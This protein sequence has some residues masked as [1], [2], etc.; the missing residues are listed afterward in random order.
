MFTGIV[1]GLGRVTA[2]RALGEGVRITVDSGGWPIEDVAIGDSIAHNGCCLTIVEKGPHW[3]TS[4]VS[5]HTLGVVC[6]LEVGALVNLEKAAT[7]ADR[8][9]GHLVTGHVDAAGRVVRWEQ[10]AESWLLEVE[11]VRELA[12]FI[13]KKGSVAVHGVSLTVNQVVDTAH[14]CRFG[15]N[16]IPHTFAA[17]SFQ[18]L[19]LGDGVNVEVDLVARYVARMLARPV[20]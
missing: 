1:S 5:A 14:G 9:G 11:V 3:L 15:I 16:I 8:L 17:T 7:L 12:P 10:I 4:D 2:H 18:A 19:R 13:A 6:G 20:D